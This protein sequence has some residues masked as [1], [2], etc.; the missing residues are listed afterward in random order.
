MTL[1]PIRRALPTTIAAALALLFASGTAIAG[2][3]ASGIDLKNADDSVRIQ[4]NFFMHVNGTWMKNT[5]IPSDHSTWGA[6]DA[7][8]ESTL[9][10]LRGIVEE[11]AK[12]GPAT[13]GSDAQKIGD[14]YASFMDEATL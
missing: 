14:L 13:P 10:Q 4:D 12:D 6:F 5:Q 7:L 1:T 9:P 3:Q 11:A 8:I 2:P